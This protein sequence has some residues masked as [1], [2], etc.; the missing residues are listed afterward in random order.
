M[1]ILWILPY[2]PWPTTS[3]GKTRQYH[4]L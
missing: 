4:L 3:G 2:S 1:R